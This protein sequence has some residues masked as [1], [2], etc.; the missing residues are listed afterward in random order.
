MKPQKEKE[1]YKIKG[2]MQLFKNDKLIREFKFH[3]AYRRK[4]VLKIWESEVKRN[5]ID[6][7]E[8]IIRI[9]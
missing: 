3:D 4:S 9:D 8:L 7:Y 6:T 5:G 1:W 2:L